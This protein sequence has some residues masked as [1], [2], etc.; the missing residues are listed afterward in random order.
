MIFLLHHDAGTA[1]NANVKCYSGVT[2]TGGIQSLI[3]DRR[4]I[5]NPTKIYLSPVIQ[6]I[7]HD[8]T[9]G[10]TDLVDKILQYQNLARKKM[11]YF[12]LYR[13]IA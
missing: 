12:T 6:F 3:S 13:I 7:Q 1:F 2:N 5:H 9:P 4:Y 11:N 10:C 8:T